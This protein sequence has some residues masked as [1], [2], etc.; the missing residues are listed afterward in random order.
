ML[1][2]YLPSAGP[3]LYGVSVVVGVG[4]REVLS[5]GTQKSGKHRMSLHPLDVLV[6]VP[7]HKAVHQGGVGMQ[8]YVEVGCVFL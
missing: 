6:R 2:L 1:W 7:I 8:V 5:V 4:Q 3:C